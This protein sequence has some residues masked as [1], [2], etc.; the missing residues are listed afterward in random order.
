[1]TTFLEALDAAIEYYEETGPSRFY[2]SSQQHFAAHAGALRSGR[3]ALVAWKQSIPHETF[4]PPDLA[5]LAA[6]L[7]PKGEDGS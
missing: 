5:V 7:S 4:F 1:M 3:D 2:K 6:V